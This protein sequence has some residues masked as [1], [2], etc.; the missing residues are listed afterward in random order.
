MHTVK[1]TEVTLYLYRTLIS[2]ENKFDTK[3]YGVSGLG[4]TDKLS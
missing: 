1:L 2:A 4:S 3:Q